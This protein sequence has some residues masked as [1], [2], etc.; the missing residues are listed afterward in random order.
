MTTDKQSEKDVSMTGVLKHSLSE[1]P[2]WTHLLSVAIIFSA[3]GFV[4]SYQIY[5]DQIDEDFPIEISNTKLTAYS[6][7]FTSSS[8]QWYNQT[9][10]TE[11]SYPT[12]YCRA[13]NKNNKTVHRCVLLNLD[14]SG[15]VDDAVV[16]TLYTECSFKGEKE[17]RKFASP[18]LDQFNQHCTEPV[19][20]SL[21]STNFDAVNPAY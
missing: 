21:N 12:P 9:G 6:L 17:Y 4:A 3:L 13:T 15:T 16:E 10:V 19:Y 20:T 1:V 14:D 11:V 8:S 2:L 5:E 18:S 7:E